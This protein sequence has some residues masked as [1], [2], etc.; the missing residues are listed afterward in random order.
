MTTDGLSL[1]AYLRVVAQWKWLVIIVTLVVAI[2]GVGY[3][4][5]RTPMYSAAT[6]LLYVQQVDISAPLGQTSID[7][8]AQ[9][10]ELESVPAVIASSQ[11]PAP[12]PR[13]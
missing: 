12:P 6:Q 9:Q 11:V 4:S 13:A 1:H 3:T 8:T 7:T 5:T 10:S 2:L